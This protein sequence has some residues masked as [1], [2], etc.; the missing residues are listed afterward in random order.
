MEFGAA[1]PRRIG[2]RSIWGRCVGPMS[3]DSSV[4]FTRLSM[5]GPSGAVEEA[6]QAPA[7]QRGERPVD[8]RRL[9]ETR[10]HAHDVQMFVPDQLAFCPFDVANLRAP[11]GAL[12]MHD[13][14]E[15]RIYPSC[16]GVDVNRVELFER[17]AWVAGSRKRFGDE[18][19]LQ[20]AGSTRPQRLGIPEQRAHPHRA[21]AQAFVFAQGPRTEAVASVRRRDNSDLE[22]C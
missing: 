2:A 1:S 11:A 13:G 16:N 17:G 9:G 8:V 5:F 19:G 21:I 12:E 7:R 14:S 22:E 3:Y 18:Q 15:K 20:L 10:R 4:G 6:R